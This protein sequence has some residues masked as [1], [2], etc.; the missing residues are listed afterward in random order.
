MP[1]QGNTSNQFWSLDLPEDEEVIG[2]TASEDFIA[3]ATNKQF[4]RLL[5]IG[6]VQREIY[7]IPG[8]FLCMA[9]SQTKLMI[10]SHASPGIVIFA[11]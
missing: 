3:V 7:S 4:L 11:S 6:G 2:L 10:V 9:A 8:R 5:T 1:L